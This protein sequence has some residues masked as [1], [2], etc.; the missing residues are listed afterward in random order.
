[1]SQAQVNLVH[2]LYDYYARKDIETA[3]TLIGEEFEWV[4]VPLGQTVRGVDGF[5]QH[6]GG[7]ARTFPDSTISVTH[8]VDGGDW[9]VMEYTFRGTH[10]G[11]L[12]TPGGEIPA[13]DK[14]INLPGCE[15]YHLDAGKIIGI[16]TYFDA[17]T[18]LQQLG[19]V[20]GA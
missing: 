5:K 1:M 6:F 14:P 19:V 18:M 2:S 8:V 4:V 16:H 7:L 11:P 15:V 9:V 3:A 17:M 10:R 20:S 12:L 13:T